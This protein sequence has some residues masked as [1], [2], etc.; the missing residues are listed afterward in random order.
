MS[1]E[2]AYLKGKVKAVEGQI[3]LI[4]NR[5]G[6]DLVKFGN[7]DLK[8][9]AATYVFMKTT[10]SGDKMT[11][12]CF[13]DMVAMLDSLMDSDT[14]LSVFVK[15]AADASKGLYKNV[16]ESRTSCSFN[17][18]ASAIFARKAGSDLHGRTVDRLFGAVKERALWTWNGG[19][20][21]MKADLN[22]EL[23]VIFQHVSEEII[24]QLG[25]HGDAANIV[26]EYLLQSKKCYQ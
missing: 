14:E 12:G 19:S 17:H 16:A 25:Q 20:Q 22:R 1:E 11:F 24:M 9:L 15:M 26:Q 3:Y 21:G 23:A 5:L 10:M 4:K 2:I 8:S 7:I 6:A 13:Y 18:A